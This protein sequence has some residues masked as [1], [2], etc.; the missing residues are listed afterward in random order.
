MKKMRLGL[1]VIL[2]FISAIPY[3]PVMAANRAGAASFILGAGNYYFSSKRHIDN[4]GLIFVG[5]GYDFTDQWGIEAIAS[6]FNTDSDN[7]QDNGKQVNGTL[8]AIDGVY[9]FSPY[10]AIQPFITA[11][12]GILGLSPNGNDARNEGNINA[13][14][15]AQY[16]VTDS[17]SFRV[18]ARDFYTINGGKNDVMLDAGMTFLFDL[19]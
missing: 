11:G 10:K 17:I 8:V 5:A 18:D 4:A 14:L 13:G 2:S 1:L 15:G 19:C 6:I 9:H 3:A 12:V 16:F 7:P